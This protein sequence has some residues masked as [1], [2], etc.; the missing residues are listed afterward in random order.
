MTLVRTPT[1]AVRE[2]GV[3]LLPS[4]GLSPLLLP[5]A[6][7]ITALAG[8]AGVAVQRA[9]DVSSAG[10]AYAQATAAVIDVAVDASIDFSSNTLL[11]IAPTP[12][13]TKQVREE[14]ETRLKERDALLVRSTLLYAQLKRSV[15]VTQ[16]YFTALQQ[17]ADGSTAEATETA[18]KS[19]ADRLNGVNQALDGG[20]GTASLISTKKR[21]AIGGLANLVVKQIHGAALG[22]ALERDAATVGRALALQNRV[23]Q[24]ASDD[25]RANLINEAERG[26]RSRVLGPFA[27]G[28]M[29]RAAWMADR[30]TFLKI[31]ALGQT[32]QALD[33]AQAAAAQMETVWARILSGEYAAKELAV[34]LK[35]TEDL[36]AA[37]SALK[38]VT[39]AE[40][41]AKAA[42]PKN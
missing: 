8:C 14:R 10:I 36:L 9:K 15:N 22:K 16:A 4:A 27:A 25:I 40:S 23:L 38:D 5:L 1:P 29:E 33:S 39:A 11:L 30:K 13:L 26:Y 21:D 18:V 32:Q 28:T 7:C 3:R 31:Q 6:L 2:G 42:A 17:L 12:P 24:A 20:E 35:D 41:P 34:M 37:A 19:L